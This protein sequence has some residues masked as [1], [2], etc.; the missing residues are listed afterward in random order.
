[1]GG[2]LRRE[3][4]ALDLLR[5]PGMD[6][7]L[8]SGLPAVGVRARTAIETDE[9]ACQIEQQVEIQ[10]RYDGY[11][12]RQEQEIERSRRYA[13]TALPQDIDY[14]AVRGLSH[15]IRQKLADI[16][17]A[18]VAQASR[19]SGMTPAAISMLLVHLKKKRLRTA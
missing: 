1:I 2:P 18:T 11:L 3:S 9:L 12:Q 6:Y 7:A 4:S 15:E 13:E 16:R 19:I 8:L 5:R 10:A 17:P 14:G